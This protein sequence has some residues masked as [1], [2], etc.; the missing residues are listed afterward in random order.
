[1]IPVKSQDIGT[2]NAIS[3]RQI[4]A[5]FALSFARFFY[6]EMQ[7]TPARIAGI[8]DPLFPSISDIAQIRPL[9]PVGRRK[10]F[11]LPMLPPA[12]LKSI[13]LPAMR[14]VAGLDELREDKP[15]AG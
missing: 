9:S 6:I 4:S 13:P 3:F 15:E 11:A 5:G 10:G 7:R 8:I 2:V 12:C 14:G 1:M